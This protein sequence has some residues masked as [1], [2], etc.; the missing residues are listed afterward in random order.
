MTKRQRKVALTLIA[1]ALMTTTACGMNNGGMKRQAG[2]ARP[3][4]EVATP[5]VPQTPQALSGSGVNMLNASEAKIPIM[6]VEGKR[7]I[8]GQTFADT[9]EFQWDWDPATGTLRIG[10]ND[11]VYELKGGSTQAVVEGNALTMAEAPFVSGDT[12]QIPLSVVE[13]LFRDVV[14]YEVRDNELAIKPNPNA[15]DKAILNL[16]PEPEGQED[17]W[18]FADDPNDPKKKK[19]AS[20]GGT[21]SFTREALEAAVSVYGRGDAIPVQVD[22]NTD[23]LISTGKRY[24]GVKYKFGTGPYPQT[25]K[26]DCSTFTQYLYGKEDV[27]LPRTARAQARKG[28]NVSRKM[29]REGDLMFFYVPGRFKTDK[30]VGHVGIYMGNNQMIHA[31]PKPK[32]GVQITNINQPYWKKTFLSAKRLDM[33]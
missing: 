12:L 2:E 14:S 4:P 28:Q 21:S 26:F 16:P 27:D 20:A 17:E 13:D 33:E 18:S 31:S 25:G 10:D 5:S 22:I 7:V 6:M 9:L 1:V 29:L 3:S 11:A 23:N 30:I 24:L 8:S 15:V 19:P 32:D